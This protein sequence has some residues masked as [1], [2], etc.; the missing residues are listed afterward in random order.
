MASLPKSEVEI[1]ALGARTPVGFSA[2]GSAAAIRARIGCNKYYPTT[3]T[4]TKR[5]EKNW[6][7]NA[8]AYRAFKG[9]TKGAQ[10]AHRVPKA[11]G[12]CPSGQ[13]NLAPTETKCAKLEGQLSELQNN[14][15]KKFR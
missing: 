4:E 7:Q 10:V 9:M 14:C 2:E 8:S 6:G 3:A 13:G 15:L 12:G 5:I 11:A 1:V